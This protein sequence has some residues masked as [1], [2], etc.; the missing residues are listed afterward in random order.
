[1]E[2]GNPN[3]AMVQLEWDMD[4]VSELQN[5][6][7][8]CYLMLK[9]RLYSVLQNRYISK[10]YIPNDTDLS[11]DSGVETLFG[12]KEQLTE[13]FNIDELFFDDRNKESKQSSQEETP[14]QIFENS[15]VRDDIVEFFKSKTPEE[16]EQQLGAEVARMVGFEQKNSHHCYDLWEHTLRTVEGIKPIGLT[17]DQFKK[18]RVAAFFHD[19]GKPDVSSFNPRTGQQVFYGHAH[20]SVD[21]AKPI[22]EGLGYSKEEIEQLSF[23]IAHHDDFIS[24][25]SK[26]APFMQN[27]EFIR[28]ISPE[29]IAEKVIENRFDFQAMGYNKD[30]IRA[31]VYTLAHRQEP[32]FRTKDGPISIPINI[33]EV[34]AK[35]NSGE[36]NSSYDASLDDYQM[37]LKLCRA[38]AGAQSEIAER[39]TPNGKKVID[40]TKAEKL[41]NMSN[42]E[43][44][45][46]L[47]Y[48]QSILY[49][50]NRL[51]RY[52]ELKEDISRKND[53]A[54]SLLSEYSEL[55]ETRDNDRKNK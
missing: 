17:P 46:P 15:L 51:Q 50:K 25:K 39:T 8:E 24:Y 53:E 30:E 19:I 52:K 31:I 33:Q 11:Y 6:A 35:I 22:L 34:K 1:M 29:T 41:E 20:H 21:V 27:H 10:K 13:P 55:L 9:D 2:N 14:R 40:G 36:Y 43:E 26:L 12:N 5:N 32:D 45:M 37:L 18:L 54:K 38:D 47:A 44:A 16:L 3:S 28:G 49:S 4:Y 42:I 48:I 7:I 23:Y